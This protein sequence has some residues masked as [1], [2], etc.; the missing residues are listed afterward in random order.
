MSIDLKLTEINA[1]VTE[2]T[3]EVSNLKTAIEDSWQEIDKVHAL[4]KQNHQA[5]R[6]WQT[7]TGKVTFK[8]LNDAEY[9]VDTLATL[10]NE[11]Q[12]INP[13][14][15]VMTKAQFDA[16]RQM[17][18][19]QYAGS[20]FV[21]WGYGDL[22]NNAV[23]NGMWAYQNK[24]NLGRSGKTSGW[25]GED[26]SSSPFS[27][28]VVDGV[29]HELQSVDY[30]YGIVSCK[31]PPAPDGTKT[32]DSAT[33]K[34]T[35]HGN[36]EPAFGGVIK[37]AA[38]SVDY[39]LPVYPEPEKPWH[40][41]ANPSRGS[42]S[43]LNK[44]LTIIDD[45]TGGEERV[46]Y[47]KQNFTLEPNTTYKATY[48]LAE[49]QRSGGVDGINFIV[50]N[51]GTER[52]SFVAHTNGDSGYF[53]LEFTTGPEGGAYYIILYAGDNGLARYN[54]VSI[55]KSTEQV[56]TSRKDLVFLES[57]HEKIADKDVVYPLGNVQFGAS[58]YEGIG[59]ANNL[60]GQGYSAFG[61]WDTN[62]KGYGVKWSTL[63]AANRVKFLKN[64]EHNIYY[65][66]EAKAYI[67]VRYR[68]RVVE[69]LGDGHGSFVS[70]NADTR[71]LGGRYDNV[72]TRFQVP[73][74]GASLISPKNY[75]NYSEQGNYLP[76]RYHAQMNIEP[77]LGL[78][79][80]SKDGS[81][82]SRTDFAHQGQCFAIPIA[83]VQRLNQGA[84]HPSYNP[85]GTGR[86][87]I[88]GGYYYTWYQTHDQLTEIRSVYDCFDSQANNGGG[89]K[90]EHGFSYI[91]NGSVYCGR[92]DQYKY[93]DAIYA[94]QV[95]DLRLNANKLD[96]NQLREDTMRKAVAGTLRGKEGP[97]FTQFK[98]LHKGYLTG[99]NLQNAIFKDSPNNGT[100][101]DLYANGFP[102]GTP[103]M[104]WQPSTNTTLYGQVSTANSHMMLTGNP[105]NLG[106]GGHVIPTT[107]GINMSDVCYFAEVKKLSAGFDSLPWVD[108][109]GHPE[110]IAATFPDGVVGQWIPK[111][112]TGEIERFTANRKAAGRQFG[113]FT[114]D[115][116]AS[117]GVTL[118]TFHSVSND[119]TNGCEVNRVQLMHY[120]S[121]S[122]CTEANALVKVIGNVGNCYITNSSETHLGNRL[123]PSL[124]SQIGINNTNNAVHNLVTTSYSFN[125][126]SEPRDESF[127]AI[128]QNWRHAPIELNA[129]NNSPAVKVLPTL[130]VKNGLYYLQFHGAELKHNRTD[131]GDDQ[132]IP[133][134]NGEDIKTDLNGNTVKVFCHHTQL[135]LGIAS[136]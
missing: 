24:L 83:L 6:N 91:E 130:T 60:V 122:I 28:V 58:T 4:A 67:Q 102:S 134:V 51:A 59:L 119:F 29:S 15:E 61:E 115:N 41:F 46:N 132:T 2:Q 112:P 57:W 42:A 26:K 37:Q 131:W 3:N 82:G 124:T 111:L 63:S 101:L 40:M 30:P 70:N 103:I 125:E 65:D 86:R 43:I 71:G 77:Q 52:F 47:A 69:G 13:H 22:T 84:Y 19:Q 23:N 39:D 38:F 55:Q 117:W 35:E 48:Y 109:I 20:G 97:L 8:D 12:K 104:M 14:P 56:I 110:R 120:E 32:Y 45:G 136:Q 11:T 118:S 113:V 100:S 87:R 27:K 121:P 50:N 135:P 36:A 16:L 44:Q 79:A 78:Y 107:L 81:V 76:Y 54:Q 88:S 99:S 34:V 128:Y 33:G 127:G 89:N 31:F 25:V 66:P 53:E 114:L 75:M 92:S 85:M 93:Y 96:V 90:G 108:I 64:P 21:E 95:E 73:P 80:A 105:S 133:I 74:Q 1:I 49:Y 5:A 7:K 72:N 116:G 62:T 106:K 68:V 10:I 18:K 123:Q 129:V 98:A 17:R 126:S 94:G 9:Q